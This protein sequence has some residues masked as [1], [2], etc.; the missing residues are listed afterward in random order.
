[1]ADIKELIGKTLTEIQRGEDTLRFICS[2]GDEFLMH[3]SQDCCESVIIEDIVGDLEDLIG[4]P[5]LK[6]GEDGSETKPADIKRDY[7]PESETWT[8]Y[9]LAT[10]KGYVTI[11]WF[12]SSNGYYSE[13]VSFDKTVG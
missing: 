10:I 12:G 9:N 11:R 7:T 13:S 8:F 6:A 5:I 4:A 3:H 2:D 1:M